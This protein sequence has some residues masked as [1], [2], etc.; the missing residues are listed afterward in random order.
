MN[1][2]V[3]SV[4]RSM[5]GI[6]FNGKKPSPKT[7]KVKQFL[8]S[9]TGIAAG[10]AVYKTL[11]K[12]IKKITD[13]YGLKVAESLQNA[14]KPSDIE[15]VQAA[16]KNAFERTGLSANGFKMH[17]VNSRE[18]LRITSKDV[19][20]KIDKVF[21]DKMDKIK[22][23]LPEKL[24][25]KLPWTKAT[26]SSGLGSQMMLSEPL[27]MTMEGKIA[28][29][30][31]ATKDIVVNLEKMP[32][33]TFHEMGHALNS[34]KTLGKILQATAGPLRALGIPLIL[35][36]GLLKRKKAD[37]EKP[38]GALDKTTTFVKNNAASLTVAAWAPTLIE[39]GMAS[40]R[41]A[42]MAKAA[43]LSS[44]LLKSLNK[45]NAKAW[46]TYLIAAA[47]TAA[48]VK[49]AIFVK[50]KIAESKSKKNNVQPNLKVA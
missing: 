7:G 47:A 36:I 14:C 20:A 34:T 19:G 31:A 35:A 13:P 21:A 27:R 40:I 25:N 6:S 11:P 23:I 49:L 18:S 15:A 9:A 39:E 29:C 48:T 38:Q 12:L 17:N 10:A 22:K 3:C 8:K 26:S 32:M 43:G 45:G 1:L 37:G 42:K 24:T 5:N 28:F 44:D 30:I 16:V 2:S 50:D 4:D 46:S 33:A 41:A